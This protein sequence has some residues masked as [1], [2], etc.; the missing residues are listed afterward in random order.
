MTWNASC[1][2]KKI[3]SFVKQK[4]LFSLKL[5]IHG[6]INANEIH[7]NRSVGLSRHK[8]FRLIEFIQTHTHTLFDRSQ[9]NSFLFF[10]CRVA[11]EHF[12]SRAQDK[13]HTILLMSAFLREKKGFPKKRT[14][15][16]THT[17]FISESLSN[18]E[19]TLFKYSTVASHRWPNR[20]ET[21]NEIR[22]TTIFL[23]SVLKFFRLFF[24]HLENIEKICLLTHF[25]VSLVNYGEKEANTV[26]FFGSVSCKFHHRHNLVVTQFMLWLTTCSMRLQCGIYRLLGL[27]ITNTHTLRWKLAFDIYSN[28]IKYTQ[29]SDRNSVT[30]FC[31]FEV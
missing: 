31:Y 26:I 18:R 6:L 4:P 7:P 9:F 29:R 20:R 15:E 19:C 30:L 25:V 23:F 21:N 5:Q 1:K 17:A 2:S 3:R 12:I 22:L 28:F 27:P 8:H 10:L 24:G 13:K 11:C 14:N 16:R